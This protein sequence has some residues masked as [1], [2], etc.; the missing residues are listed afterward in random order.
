M[1]SENGD[2]YKGLR[3]GLFMFECVMAVAYLA[4]GII[5]SLTNLLNGYLPQVWVRIGLGIA[6]G[7]YGAF[8]VFRAYR[9]ITIEND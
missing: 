7:L 8:R 3:L 4:F 2:K 9:K 6:F 5:L 1:D